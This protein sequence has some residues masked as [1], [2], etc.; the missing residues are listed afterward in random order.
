[1]ALWRRYRYLVAG[2]AWALLLGP[3]AAFLV[4]GFAA[5][6]SWLWLFG[7]DAWPSYTGWA[8]PLVGVLGGLGVAAAC[9][10]VA[11]AAGRQNAQY[12]VQSSTR[13]R[14]AL[15]L[16]TAMPLVLLGVITGVIAKEAAGY[17]QTMNFAT[18]REAEF[19]ALMG[20]RHRIVAIEVEPVAGGTFHASVR[21]AGTR[22]GPYRLT[23]QVEDSNFAMVLVIGTRTVELGPAAGQE[24]RFE[25][26]L[27][28]LAQSYRDQITPAGGVIVEE[29]FRLEV[30]LEPILSEIERAMLPPGERRNFEV[31]LS[32]LRVEGRAMFPI[33]FVL[34]TD[35][36]IEP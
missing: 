20:A 30:F 2:L 8:L 17:R 19:A 23:W 21:V 5:G 14:N 25:F 7:D 12:G 24:V 10:A 31:G 15:L 16:M 35:G 11:I 22:A 27:L 29:D 9:I 32:P 3:C 13:E 4:F 33:R 18:E 34:Q 36:S 26:V 6:V 1:M 28:E